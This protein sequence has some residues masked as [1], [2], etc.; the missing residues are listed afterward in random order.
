MVRKKTPSPKPPPRLQKPSPQ[1]QLAGFMVKYTPEVAANATAILKRMR[2]LLPGA[3]EIVYDNYN[4]LAIGFGPT[5]KTSDAVFSIALYPR[6]VTLFFLNGAKLRDPKRMLRGSGNQ[7]RNVILESAKDL[8]SP[9]VKDFMQQAIAL[10]PVE[11]DASAKGRMIIRSVSAKQ[12]PR[13]PKGK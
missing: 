4:A 2:E 1:K 9:E 8:D 11:F 13:R 6:Y 10:S 3:F 12:R 5:E 7:V